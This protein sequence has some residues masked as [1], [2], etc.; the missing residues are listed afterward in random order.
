[1]RLYAPDMDEFLGWMDS[2]GIRYVVLRN[3]PAFLQGWPVLGGKDDVDMLVD[4]GALER[5]GARYGRYS[6]MQGVKCDLYDRSGSA[7]GA[8]QGLAYYPPA[9]ADLLLD[10]RERLEGRFWIPQ[11]K[12][13][14][15]GLIFHIAYHKAERSKIDRLDP[16]ASEG[17]KYVAELRDLMARAGEAFPL[18]LTAFHERLKAEAMA[19]PYRQLAAILINDFQR[20]VKSRFLAEVANEPAGEM[21][22][23]V[24]RRVASARGQAKMLLDAIA[25]EYE[26]LVDKAIPWLTR[27][28]T[29]RKIRGGKWARGGPP[30]HAVIVFDRNPIT[31]TGDEARPHPFVFNGR[32]FMKKGLRDRFSKLTGLHTRHN[33]LHSTDNEAEAL[34][35][36]NLYFT[37]E[38]REALYQRLETIRAEMARAESPA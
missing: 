14:L 32:Q 23:F 29:N 26:I 21:N 22:L 38:E 15:L 5:I 13:Y 9:L 11:P 6:K 18:T 30:V 36:L 19:V 12:A 34:G 37:P 4:D 24:I 3:A 7:R 33:P 28:K 25:G 20:H 8:Y 31:A 10:N 17:S 16:A 35:H 2:Q 1:M 27:L